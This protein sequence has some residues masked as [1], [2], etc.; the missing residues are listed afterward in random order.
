MDDEPWDDSQKEIH[1]FAVKLAS[2]KDSTSLDEKVVQP[3]LKLTK[4]IGK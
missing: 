3:L 2:V 1:S 4:K